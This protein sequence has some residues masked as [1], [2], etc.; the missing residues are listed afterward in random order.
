[1][2][3]IYVFDAY[4]TLLD[5]HS[6]VSALRAEVGPQADRLSELWRSKQ[7]E[8]TWVLTLAQQYRPFD[9]LT[10]EAL[11]FAAA[12]IGG[13]TEQLKLKLLESYRCLS[14][15]PDVAQTMRAL[16][17]RGDVTAIFSN[18]TPKMLTD[19]LA[20]AKLT[21]LVD[22]TI[23]VDSLRLYKTHPLAYRLVTNHFQCAAEEIVFQSSNRWDIAGARAFG[24]TCNWV[25]RTGMP[26]EYAELP[27]ER[28]IASLSELI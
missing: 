15:Y 27:P 8:Y 26:E 2:S 28:V 20:A 14:A 24:F 18:G 12:R 13:L 22:V 10:R 3:T 9:E 7:L 21:D 17:A 25:N 23:S 4:G 19:A 5:V 11:N 1:M 6:A 16:K